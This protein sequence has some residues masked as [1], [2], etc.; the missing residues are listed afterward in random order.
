MAAISKHTQAKTIVFWLQDLNN[1]LFKYKTNIE[2]KGHLPY[3]KG[4]SKKMF[5]WPNFRKL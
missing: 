1:V 2:D 4:F 3:A 5:H